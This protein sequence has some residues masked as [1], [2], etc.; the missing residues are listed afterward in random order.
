MT[1]DDKYS[2]LNTDNSMQPI[3]KHLSQKQ[4]FFSQYPSTFFEFTFHFEQIKK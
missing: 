3:Q 2:L 4:K 1:V